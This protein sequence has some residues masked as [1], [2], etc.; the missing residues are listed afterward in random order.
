MAEGSRR[1]SG[2][3]VLADISGYT[4]FLTGTELEHA[5]GIIEDLTR[6]ILGTLTP[7]LTLVKLEGDAAFA[8]SPEGRLSGD[9]ILDVVERTYCDFADCRDDM[10]RRTTC[11]CEACANI[12]SLDLKF[13]VH[14]G[15]YLT[16]SVGGVEDLAGPDVIL[17][18]RLLKN[19]V[20]EATGC[21]AYA[22]LT[23][24]AF[25]TTPGVGLRRQIE[26]TAEFGEVEAGVLDLSESLARLRDSRRVFLAPEECDFAYTMHL[27]VPP[28]EAW[29]W[30][31]NPARSPQWQREVLGMQ[32]ERNAL[33]R[34]GVEGVMH[35]AHGSYDTL[36]RYLDWRPFEY[37]TAERVGS[38]KGLMV[39]P[40][41]VE[42]VEF[43]ATE[44]N[45]TIVSYRFRVSDRRLRSQLKLRL[46]RP[47]ARR[48]FMVAD[49][50][51]NALIAKHEDA[52]VEDAPVA[53]E[54]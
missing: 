6:A 33:G 36:A 39:P 48:T 22:L 34:Q 1:R 40:D 41:W 9:R 5:Q 29:E 37:Y 21:R 19:D 49:R 42:T 23:E 43:V 2:F 12:P 25:A 54:G 20:R 10:Q 44:D 4:A 31:T 24:A 14:H 52:A 3:L 30:W 8:L 32:L 27:P 50:D 46:L 16:H 11:T 35:C 45:G 13:V 51:L 53:A 38:R 17:V 18:H 7:P 47:M 26:H 15:E 28:A